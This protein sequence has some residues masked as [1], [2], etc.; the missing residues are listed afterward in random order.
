[1]K[2]TT[3]SLDATMVQTSSNENKSSDL[4]LTSTVAGITGTVADAATVG[5]EIKAP[6]ATDLI[7]F[8]KQIGK[9]GFWVG[10]SS[11]VMLSVQGK[12]SYLKTT[13]GAGVGYYALTLP[14]PLGLA[15]GGG[16]QLIDKTVGW[17]AVGR[18]SVRAANTVV[19]ETGK[20]VWEK[21]INEFFKAINSTLPG[22][23]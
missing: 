22:P 13:I 23:R 11:D 19:N 20:A 4:E 21:S 6:K 9:T 17:E 1:M 14:A 16:Y 7:G 3:V 12:Q 8:T 10:T 2:P 15:V 18:C 5:L